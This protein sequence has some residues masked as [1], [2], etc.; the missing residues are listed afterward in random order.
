M[1]A[2]THIDAKAGDGGLCLHTILLDPEDL[3]RVCVAISTGGMYVTEDGCA[4]S[5]PSNRG[6]RSDFIPDKHP[7]LGQCV[8]KVVQSKVQPGPAVARSSGPRTRVRAGRSCSTDSPVI[9]VK[10]ATI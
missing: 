2:I 8:H 9:S 3:Q 1:P 4:T 6:V 10:V 7:V 5:R